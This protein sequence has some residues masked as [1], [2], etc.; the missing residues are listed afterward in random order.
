MSQSS[1]YILTAEGR[2]KSLDFFLGF[3]MFLLIAEAT[4]IYEH[5]VNPAFQ[6]A[7]IH[8]I[9][10]QCHCQRRLCL[11]ALGFSQKPD[12]AQAVIRIFPIVK[13]ESLSISASLRTVNVCS[14]LLSSVRFR[15]FL[16]FPGPS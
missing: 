7:I 2:L 3:T 16:N 1:D 12:Q 9:G 6:G 15:A 10:T 13:C 11:L 14:G 5:L 8:A 4:H